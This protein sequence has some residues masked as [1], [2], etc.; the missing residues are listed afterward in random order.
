MLVGGWDERIV[1]VLDHARC[2]SFREC[3]CRRVE[4]AQ[5]DVA[6]PPNHEADRVCINT[7]HE[8]VHGAAGPHRSRADIF[9]RESHLGSH[10]SGC[11]G[12]HC[13]DLR[14]ADC[15]PC[16]SVENGGKVRVW[17]GTVLS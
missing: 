1:P 5:H 16:S 14:T 8:K 10:E 4:V 3:L 12:Y 11:G 2:E 15:G 6:A 13:G 7:F 17:V 9:W